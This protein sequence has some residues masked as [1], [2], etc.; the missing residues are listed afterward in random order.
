MAA[1]LLTEVREK[2]DSLR[3][4][5]DDEFERAREQ[6]ETAY[7]M[8]LCDSGLQVIKFK[9]KGAASRRL[10]STRTAAS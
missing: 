2:I 10:S 3:R 4:S 5:I 9:Q 1:S 8:A 7:W 6:R